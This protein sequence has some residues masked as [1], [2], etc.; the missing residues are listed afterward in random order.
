MKKYKTMKLYKSHISLCWLGNNF[1]MGITPWGQAAPDRY[2]K[3]TTRVDDPSDLIIRVD[4]LRPGDNLGCIAGARLK[5]RVGRKGLRM[6]VYF[7]H[8]NQNAKN[9]GNFTTLLKPHNIGTHW[10][11]IETSF[12]AVLLFL[13]FFL[14]WVSYITFCNFLKMPSVFNGINYDFSQQCCDMQHTK[15]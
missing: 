9:I 15:S 3:K 12:Q 1:T 13:I 8:E 5:S 11:G 2:N 6:E 7:C 10:K 14:F 4:C